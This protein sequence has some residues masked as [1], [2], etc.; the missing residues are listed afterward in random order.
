MSEYRADRMEIHAV[1][2]HGA[3]RAVPQNM[4]RHMREVGVIHGSAYQPLQ[5]HLLVLERQV[6]AQDTQSRMHRCDPVLTVLG[7]KSVRQ[8]LIA[9]RDRHQLTQPHPRLERKPNE[10]SS[11]SCLSRTKKAPVFG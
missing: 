3:G 1:V 2:D 5:P 10:R 4:L 6:F 9:L 11:T 7:K 8:N